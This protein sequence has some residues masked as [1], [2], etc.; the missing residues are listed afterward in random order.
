[1]SILTRTINNCFKLFGFEIIKYEKEKAWKVENAIL[2]N[3][4][5]KMN[6]FYS[7]ENF[8]DTYIG[9]DKIE[10]YKEVLKLLKSNKIDL[11]GLTV[12]DVGCGTGHLLHFIYD[13]VG[14]KRGIGLEYSLEA[15]RIA[16]Q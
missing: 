5:E 1:M 11:S 12:A 16:K 2:H 8:L 15:I 10:F 7:Q 13:Q 9:S 4:L 14:F 3:S 6:E